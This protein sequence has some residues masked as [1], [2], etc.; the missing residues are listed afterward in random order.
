MKNIRKFTAVI[1]SAALMVSLVAC[2]SSSS[3]DVSSTSRVETAEVSAEQEAG[4]DEG[5]SVSTGTRIIVDH[6]DREVEI[7]EEINR[8]VILNI[9]PL[10]SVYCLFEGSAEKLVGIHPSS[11]DAAKNSILPLVCPDILD[12]S[13]DFL[14]NGELN[15]EELMNLHP[16]VA[17]YNAGNEEELAALTA[18]GIPAI[19]FSAAKWDYNCVET[20]DSWVKLLGEVLGQ[21]EKAQEIAD[22]GYEVYDEITSVIEEAGDDLEKPRILFLFNYANGVIKTSGSHHPGQFWADSTGA[23]NVAEELSGTP[24]VNMEQIYEWDP[25]IIYITNFSPY[26]PEDLINNTIEGY[27]WS[28]VKAVKDGKVYK[29]P[30][31]MYRWFPPASDTPLALEWIATKNHPELFGD[32]DMEEEVRTYY[33]RFYDVELTDDMVY[34]IFN[35]ASEAS[36]LTK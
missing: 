2:G 17:F 31:G 10:P 35:P 16:D 33:K 1:L 36:G 15:V 27:D 22:Y 30:L 25:D 9:L 7:P 14:S 26:E 24:E 23:I 20:F 21:N 4:S 28:S 5:S 6:A 13:T 3:S 19:G 32:I 12:V 34:Q 11:M 29:F 8:I 18:A